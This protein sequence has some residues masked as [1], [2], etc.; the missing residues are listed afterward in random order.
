MMGLW[1]AAGQAAE[2]ERSVVQIMTFAQQPSWDAPWRFD[3]V[4]RLGGSGFVIKGK[5]IMT[6]A[7]VVSWARQIIVRRYQDPRPYLAEVEYVGHDCDL[8]VLRVEDGRF[9]ENLE[10]LSFGG[11][12]KVR[13]TVV[14]YVYPAGGRKSLTRA[15]WCRAS[16]SR[17]I[18]IS[19]TAICSARRPMPRSTRG[20]AAVRSSRMIGWSGSPFKACRASRIPVSSS[21]RR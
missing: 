8:A 1:A 11:L 2:A 19:G 9:F 18:H 14:T 21:R 3:A 16:N 12:P 13:S 5:R 20:T 6:N 15:A 7:H 10:P 17:P 4:R